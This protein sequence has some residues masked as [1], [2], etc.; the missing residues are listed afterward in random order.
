M[1]GEAFPPPKG[2]VF[3]FKKGPVFLE[4]FFI[5]LPFWGLEKKMGENSH[6][7]KG[8]LNR[9]GYFWGFKFK[10]PSPPKNFFLLKKKNNFF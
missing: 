10:K 7:K 3:R 1:G 9:E 4:K 2:V 6:F 5:W 8:G